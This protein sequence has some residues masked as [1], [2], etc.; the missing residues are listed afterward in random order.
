MTKEFI[1]EKFSPDLNSMEIIDKED[2]DRKKKLAA[3]EFKT[4]YV[5]GKFNSE[6]INEEVLS[7]LVEANNFLENQNSND[8]RKLSKNL[9]EEAEKVLKD[10]LL[11]LSLFEEFG[12]LN[13]KLSDEKKSL[14][15]VLGEKAQ[16]RTNLK[17]NKAIAKLKADEVYQ[18]SKSRHSIS[19]DAHT[20]TI[21]DWYKGA[22]N[23]DDEFR[24]YMKKESTD[25]EEDWLILDYICRG[26]IFKS[27]L[28]TSFFEDIDLDWSENKPIVRSLVL[29]TLKSIKEE[30]SQL[31][32]AD[33][34]YNWEDDSEYVQDLFKLTVDEND[35]LEELLSDKLRNWDI[36]RIALTDKVLLKMALIEM[37]HFPSIPTKELN[38]LLKKKPCKPPGKNALLLNKNPNAIEV[39]KVKKSAYFVVLLRGIKR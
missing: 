25:Y 34:S 16:I 20:D 5:D 6:G 14:T 31:Q 12:F 2:L 7:E 39:H 13:K 21:R 27:D 15:N 32:I 23:K 29:K 17:D 19:W 30:D 22:L 38:Q 35:Y 26:V 28:F 9:R 11:V 8:F 37:I 24:A 33:I 3:N 1:A 4:H 36:E 10:H 18:K